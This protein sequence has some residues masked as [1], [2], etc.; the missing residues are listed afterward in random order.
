MQPL[1]AST[2]ARPSG[3][4][5]SPL[6]LPIIDMHTYR[7]GDPQ[8]KVELIEQITAKSQTLGFFYLVNHGL[9]PELLAG[10]LEW[11]R[12]F[13]AL[14]LEAK[15]AVDFRN[16]PVRRGYEPMALQTLQAGAPPDQ[17]EGFTLGLNPRLDA[18]PVDSPFDGPNQWPAS[19]PGFDAVGF[20]AQMEAYRDAMVVLGRE[21]CGLLAAS[22]DLPEDYFAEALAKPNAS[23]RVL[24]YPP[25][26][27]PE[28]DD[29]LG[30]GAHTDWGFITLLLQDDCGGLEIEVDGKGWLKA[31]PQPGALIINLGDM[32]VRLTA[33]RYASNVHRVLNTAPGK[34]RYSVATF[35]NPHSAY[36]VD[37]VPSCIPPSG[38]PEPIT[39][40]DHIQEMI[41][42]TYAA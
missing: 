32:V 10:Q 20:R 21:I 24:H 29:K 33:G 25:R 22:L 16:L 15:Q 6:S 3:A 36:K 40:S 30:C 23:V 9:P 19:Q 8:A 41:R 38:K 1:S 42:K 31:T 4:Q 37:C 18:S 27:A 35:F 26:V 11:A 34:D 2:L 12:R 5:D 13:F 28:A 39:F 17:K 7:S 14:P